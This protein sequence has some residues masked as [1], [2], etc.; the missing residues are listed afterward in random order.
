[1]RLVAL[2]TGVPRVTRSQYGSS[3]LLQLGNGRSFLFDI[4]DVSSDCIR[5]MV[6]VGPKLECSRPRLVEHLLPKH[7]QSLT[8][9]H[10][11]SNIKT[12]VP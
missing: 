1:M 4:G 7:T 5:W 12:R 9:D 3:Y 8:A 6:A 2:G 10:P 11:T